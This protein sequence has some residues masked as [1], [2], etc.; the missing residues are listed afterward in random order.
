MTILFHGPSGCGKDTQVEILKEKFDFENIGT[1]EMFRT[2]YSE[3]DIDA[4]KANEYLS[5]GIFVPN[6]LT[7]K[8]FPKWLEKF[9][10]NKSWAF[11]S[12]VRDVGQIAPF[13]ALL[14]EK[15][16]TLDKFIHFTL[17]E[18]AAVERMSLRWNC[19][20][21]GAIYHEKYKQEK[22]KGYCDKCGTILVQ[23]EDDQP[24][25]IAKRLEEYN[26]TIEPILSEYRNRGILVEV[27]AS[28]SIE[29]I[30]QN[31]IKVLSL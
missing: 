17:T 28:P 23:R 11:V 20:N 6:D 18:E 10:P 26:R 25:K 4:I 30:H 16:R 27:D 24:S 15:N 21:C 3:G 19:T 9:N 5:K 8:M 2:M 7:Y 14:K 12:V 1:G 31:I 29:E 13:D 22:I